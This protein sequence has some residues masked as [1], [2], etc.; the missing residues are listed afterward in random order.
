MSDWVG[1][2]PNMV[3]E[4]IHQNGSMG[5]K[6]LC[7]EQGSLI[8]DHKDAVTTRGWCSFKVFFVISSWLIFTTRVC[9]MFYK[10]VR[11]K[12]P[13]D[14]IQLSSRKTHT[15][16][17]SLFALSFLFFSSLSVSSAVTHS[18]IDAYFHNSG[19]NSHFYTPRAVTPNSRGVRFRFIFF[20]E[21]ASFS[22]VRVG[23]GVSSH[24]HTRQRKGE[25]I[26]GVFPKNTHTLS[27]SDDNENT[28]QYWKREQ[29]Y[30]FMVL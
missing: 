22:S 23:L 11:V 14:L 4:G 15:I 20:T 18:S 19:W 7:K 21:V 13:V 9:I 17:Y 12:A 29:S 26:L 1:N 10:N 2:V 27:V 28:W 8:D 5:R 25:E 24:Y 30:L 6:C 16:S 3:T